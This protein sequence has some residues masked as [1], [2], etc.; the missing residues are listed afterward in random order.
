MKATALLLVFLASTANAAL[1]PG[2]PVPVRILYDNSGSMYAGYQPPGAADRRTRA[3]LGAR[4]FH[5]SPGFAQWLHDFVRRQTILEAGT[6]GMWTFTSHDRFTPDDIHEVHPAVAADRFDVQAAIRNFPDRT[7]QS[8]YLTETIRHFTRGFTGVVWLVTDNIVETHDG[9][10]DAGVQQFFETL[11]SQPEIRSVHLFKYPIEE[12]GRRAALA[13]YALLVSAAEVPASTLAHYDDKFRAL[14]DAKRSGGADLFPAREH[15]K[16]KDLAIKP[17]EPELGLVLDHGENGLFKEGQTV[18]LNVEGKIHSY[19]TQ[20]SV[21]GGRWELAIA[22]PFVAEEW[23]QRDLGAQPLVAQMFDAIGGEIR[24]PIRPGGSRAVTGQLR[25]TQPVTFSPRG[26]AEWLRL[27]WSGA[28]VRYTATAQMAFTDVRVRLE[29]QRM[30][31]IFGIGHASSVFDF[32]NVTTLRR[33]EPT[34]FPVSFALRTGSSRTA[35]LLTVL[36]ILVAIAAAI[37]FLLSRTQVFRIAISGTPERI[38]ALRRLG[39]HDVVLDGK[40]LG[41]LSRSLVDG[42]GFD[43]VRGDASLTVV[44]AGEPDTWD[45]RLTG[46]TTRRLSIKADGGGRSRPQKQKAGPSRAAPPPPPPLPSS[47]GVPPRPPRIGRT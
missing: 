2:A 32:Q 10:P 39:R 35:I 20:H 16:L 4:F 24:E 3:E 38:T 42:F 6:V 45:V 1:R 17:V 33:V 21:T 37:A 41:R 47:K 5:Q 7:G 31:G 18:H 19:L 12:D 15:L 34:R 43:P 36:A 29:P 25:S 28:T 22:S 14:R 46:G 40:R 26:I 30:A 8:T 9:Q 27:A 44:P 13:V 11:E 23:A